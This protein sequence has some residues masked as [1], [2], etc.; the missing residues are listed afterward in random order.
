[1]SRLLHYPCEL[2]VL[3]DCEEAY[4]GPDDAFERCLLFDSKTVV[5]KTGPTYC[6]VD[7]LVRQFSPVSI[8][9]SRGMSGTWCTEADEIAQQDA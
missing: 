4:V 3:R 8:S 7:L 9:V 2:C 6:V 1:L 5:A